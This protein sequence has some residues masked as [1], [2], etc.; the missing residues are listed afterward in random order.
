MTS[1]TSINSSIHSLLWT[2]SQML[3]SHTIPVGMEDVSMMLLLRTALK[4]HLHGIWLTILKNGSWSKTELSIEKSKTKEN[5]SFSVLVENQTLL[6]SW[7]LIKF[8]ILPT[9]L[10][11][12]LESSETVSTSILSICLRVEIEKNNSELWLIFCI[13]L[14]EHSSQP[15]WNGRKLLIL[16][17]TMPSTT[18]PT[19]HMVSLS[20]NPME[21][22]L[23]LLIFSKKNSEKTFQT[24]SNKSISCSTISHQKIWMLHLKVHN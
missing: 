13:T 22:L 4:T 8:K 11:T 17:N 16:A 3:L 19:D 15:I 18:T 7:A 5:F 10:Y 6:A 20:L 12:S 14:E 23:R 1:S 2:K 9:M 21:S 24:L